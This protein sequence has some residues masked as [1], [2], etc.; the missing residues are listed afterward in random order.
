MGGHT[1]EKLIFNGKRLDGRRF[2]EVR[3]MK[4]E[5]GQLKR[6]DGSGSFKFGDTWA[7]AGVHGPRK[8]FP[9]REEKADRAILRAEYRMAP[10]STGERSRPGPNRRSTEISMVT[11][12]ALL[13]VLF[14]EEFPKTAIDADIEIL[15]AG[16]STRCAGINA[17]AIALADAGVPMRDLVS[18]CSAGVINGQIVLDVSGKEDTAGELDMPIAYYHGKKEITLIQMDGIAAP[19]RVKELLKLAIKGCEQVYEVQKQ[20]L[21][22]KYV[23]TDETE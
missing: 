17:A 12:K 2:D 9:R 11:R 16:A 19:E 10:F 14:T 3:P 21:R 8:V 15:Q 22:A 18:S 20:A 7:I 5:I 4:A 1:D 23:V 13:P 6:A